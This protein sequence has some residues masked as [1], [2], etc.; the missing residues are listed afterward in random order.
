MS[1]INLFSNVWLYFFSQD[2]QEEHVTY[3]RIIQTHFIS[4]QLKFDELIKFRTPNKSSTLISQIDESVKIEN[5]KKLVNC[6]AAL[7][8]KIHNLVLNGG[9]TLIIYNIN[10]ANHECL[11]G[12]YLYFLKQTAGIPLDKAAKLLSSKINNIN[13]FMTPDIKKL[14]YLHCAGD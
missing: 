13:Y 7:T 2:N 8:K 10:P 3:N 6:W 4:S 12:F 1:L 9:D 11:I 14:L 5:N